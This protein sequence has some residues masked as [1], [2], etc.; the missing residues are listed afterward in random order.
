MHIKFTFEEGHPEQII[1]AKAGETILDVAHNNKI[2]L[3][4]NCGGVCGCSTCHVYI[5]KGM[6][7][8]PEIEDIE[9]DFIDRAIDPR[10]SSRLACQ[11]IIS[12]NSE[13]IEITIPKQDFN[14]H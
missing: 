11:C 1:E 2:E 8:L 10:I 6:E 9:E 14:G 3:Q 4:H 13:N 12:E 5:D 7:T